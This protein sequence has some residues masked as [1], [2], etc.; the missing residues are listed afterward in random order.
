MTIPKARCLFLFFL[1]VKMHQKN[2][3]KRVTATQNECQEF[4]PSTSCIQF[5]VDSTCLE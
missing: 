3:V 2:A 1:F 5:L 4:P